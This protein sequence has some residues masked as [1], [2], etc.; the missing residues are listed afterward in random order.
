MIRLIQKI[1]NK[2]NQNILKILTD[3]LLLLLNKLGINEI[4]R[5][6][7]RKKI[8]ILMYHG[9]IEDDSYP[10][11]RTDV[12]KSNFENHLKY[13]IKKNY[14][15]ITLTQLFEIIKYKKKIKQ[16][17]VILTFDDG[18]KNIIEIAYPLIKRYKAKGCIFV[19]SSIIGNNKLLWT[20]Y[21]NFILTTYNKS[22]FQFYFKNQKILYY[23]NSK[24]ELINTYGDIKNKLRSLNNIEL[25]LHLKQFET[26]FDIE[27][28]KNISYNYLIANW[29]E[30]KAFDQNYIEI[31][32]HTRTHP[33]LVNLKTEK[34]FYDELFVSKKE[35]E[36]FIGYPINHLSYPAGSYNKKVIY[37]SKKFGFLTGTTIN[38]GLNT[39]NTDLLQLKRIKV[40][41]NSI[42]FKYKISGLYYYIKKFI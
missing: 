25:N 19:V 32:C 13:L 23:I 33:N 39:K 38:E 31:A 30:L 37:Y 6:I 1:F 4:F 22:E 9:I 28:Y 5:L 24:K 12:I 7:N 29:E 16:R 3:F 42:L 27:N 17:Y 18:F 34:E 14:T 26:I 21:L 20:D 36:N 35:I 10:V 40:D 41:N 2:L 11:H 15:F 8:S